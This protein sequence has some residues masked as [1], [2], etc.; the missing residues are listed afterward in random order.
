MGYTRAVRRSVKPL[1]LPMFMSGGIHKAHSLA[2]GPVRQTKWESFYNCAFSY[3]T[4]VGKHTEQSSTLI[5]PP[6]C[7]CSGTHSIAAVFTCALQQQAN[8]LLV[9]DQGLVVVQVTAIVTADLL[10]G[11]VAD[12]TQSYLQAASAVHRESRSRWA[13]S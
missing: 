6:G 8:R 10:S 1:H 4:A 13:V 7:I 11:G 12:E 2:A 5:K 3:S 9:K